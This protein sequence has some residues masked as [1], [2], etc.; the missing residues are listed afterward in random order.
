MQQCCGIEER[1]MQTL[2]CKRCDGG[3]Q[4]ALWG[5]PRASRLS[6]SPLS[7]SG[8]V[9][10]SFCSHPLWET[11]TVQLPLLT[12]PHLQDALGGEVEGR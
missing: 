5:C 11:C 2:R 10:G 1:Y 3:V 4:V 12:P 7:L 8:P 6:P 9:P